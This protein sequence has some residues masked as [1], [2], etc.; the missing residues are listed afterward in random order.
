MNTDGAAVELTVRSCVVIL[1]II[2]SII[3][4]LLFII[5]KNHARRGGWR[6]SEAAL[7]FFTVFFG[8]I[9]SFIGMHLMHHKTRHRDF[10]IGVPICALIQTAV[11]VA[12][13]ILT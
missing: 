12:L 8:G 11:L 9:G 6:I 2:M 3:S 1:A 13:T 10:R 4:L 7:W 5:D